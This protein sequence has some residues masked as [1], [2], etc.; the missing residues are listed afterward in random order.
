MSDPIPSVRLS[1]LPARLWERVARFDQA[2][3]RRDGVLD[4]QE[5]S[6]LEAEAPDLYAQA[7]PYI[8]LQTPPPQGNL[9]ARVVR[10]SSVS[11]FVSTGGAGVSLTS[12]SLFH[13][14]HWFKEP[15]PLLMLVPG[16]GIAA[17]GM[18]AVDRLIVPTGA[19]LRAN[20][21]T[22]GGNL[23]LSMPTMGGDKLSF[24][25]LVTSPT[26]VGDGQQRLSYGHELSA[27]VG[28]TRLSLG[29]T[30]LGDRTLTARV[31]IA[32]F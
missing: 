22:A 31:Q 29:G 3:G 10:G 7:K 24:G 6:K 21:G 28:P 32:R 4:A 14:A 27:A 30:Y 16:V 15:S 1:D 9:G 11:A 17:A 18:Y 23:E 12:G 8:R 19:R 5:L 2:G 25:H 13:R 26:W 20:A